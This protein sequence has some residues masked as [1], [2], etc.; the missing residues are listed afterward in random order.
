MA[1]KEVR[2]LQYLE[3]Y[4]EKAG[5]QLIILYGQ[6]HMAMNELL[7]AFCEDKPHSFFK[8]RPC[9]ERE[10]LFL[11]A[12]E[13]RE[14][15]SQIQEYPE[16]GEIFDVLIERRTSKRI[17]VIEEFQNIVKQSQAFMSQLIRFLKNE[18]NNQAVMIVLCSTSIGWVE[19]S[20][21]SKIGS[22]IYDISGLIK[23][24]ECGIGELQH[25]F[26]GNTRQEWV[27]FYA[28]LGGFPGLW[29]HFEDGCSIKENICRHLLSQDCFLHEE[30][31]RMVSEQ[32]RET[33]VYHT[34]LNALAAGKQKLNELYLHTSFSRAKIS[35]YLKNLMELEI[36]EKVFSYDTAGREHTQKGIYRI[37]NRLVLFYFR[38]LYPH[39]SRLEML[40]PE[41]F[42]EAYIEPDFLEF[43]AAAFCQACRE[44]LEQK[45]TA[46]QLPFV[47]TKT[48]EWVGK[49]GNID[50][51]AEDEEGN[52]LIGL[53]SWKEAALSYE[54]YEWLMFCAK[55]ARISAR[56]IYLFSASGFDDR[57]LA[58]AGK[59]ENLYLMGIEVF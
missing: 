36:V 26:P 54:D 45:N 15:G 43:S 58:E 34:I 9:S 1:G 23:M 35:V 59:N 50:V 31:L 52:A 28:V 55:K 49:V 11:W 7:S 6:K 37:K 17:I 21:V 38:Y 25:Y 27:G 56:Y 46:G 4:Y 19:N 30:A 32:L 29:R 39:L 5:S 18:W 40:S 20:M 16:Y 48:G 3:R 14:D 44:L 47:Y 42:F 2:E 57:L 41:Q 33:G 24:K 22:A 51:I 12:N 13:L 53:C 10:Q 8:A